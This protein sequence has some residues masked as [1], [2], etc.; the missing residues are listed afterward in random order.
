MR[1]PNSRRSRLVLGG[2]PS[3]GSS[4]VSAAIPLSGAVFLTSDQYAIWALV[5]TLSTIFLLFDF[6]APALAAKVS[7]EGNASRST[8]YKICALTGLPPL[9]LAAVGCLVWAPYASAADLNAYSASEVIAA[10]G[11]I[12]LGGALR[13]VGTVFAG[14]SLGRQ[15]YGARAII[16]LIPA[17]GSAISTVA[18]LAS[19]FGLWSLAAGIG[20]AGVLACA[21]GAFLERHRDTS[22]DNLESSRLVRLFFV[23]KGAATILGL[24]VTQLDRW[25]LGLTGDASLLAQY[26]IVT[27]LV[28]IPKVALLALLVGLITEAA[29]SPP[30]ELRRLWVRSTRFVTVA[31][32]AAQLLCIPAALILID[33]SQ[34]VSATSLA[35]AIALGIAQTALTATIPATYIFSGRGEP[36]RELAYLLPLFVLVIA[37]YVLGIAM[38]D[39]GVIV[40]GWALAVT[41]LS[42]F[43]LVYTSKILKGAA[44]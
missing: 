8:V 43:Y 5:S 36:Q 26:D 22:G 27:R 2:I 25:A 42:V 16:L 34:G 31:F 17:A 32:G 40:G 23:S 39:G 11:A 35:V 6:G 3:L 37:S 7:A 1:T 44:I 9:L 38:Q 20:I 12:G 29:S 24:A 4:A 15:H 21:L 18:L 10:T 41:A 30:A 28:Q 33:A 13:S 19:G 14:L